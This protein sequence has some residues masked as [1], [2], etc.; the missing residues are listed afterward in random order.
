MFPP[1][2]QPNQVYTHSLAFKAD[3]TGTSLSQKGWQ[4]ESFSLVWFPKGKT[5]LP[6]S[7][8]AT[9]FTRLKLHWH[10]HIVSM[11]INGRGGKGEVGRNE[12]S[13]GNLATVLYYE[14]DWWLLKNKWFSLYLSHLSSR[15][16]GW[17]SHFPWF[18][19]FVTVVNYRNLYEVEY[20]IPDISSL[21]EIRWEN[22]EGEGVLIKADIAIINNSVHN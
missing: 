16:L 19:F 8:E 12:R 14:I 15:T 11:Y 1:E 17:N 6:W 13:I 7:H 22:R 20:T 9:N 4:K 2:T 10:C 18:D 5:S 21:F 3:I